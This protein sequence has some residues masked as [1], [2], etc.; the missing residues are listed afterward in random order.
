MGGKSFKIDPEHVMGSGKKLQGF[1]SKISHH[2]STLASTGQ[3]LTSLAGRDKSGIGSV[4][5]K[6][7]GRGVNIA[8][9]MFKE[10]GQYVERMGKH[11][12]GTGEVHAHNEHRVR[13]SFDKIRLD[14]KGAPKPHSVG[15]GPKGHRPGEGGG[16]GV[17]KP[18]NIGHNGGG[19]I[20][21]AM[22]KAG[23]KTRGFAK[24]AKYKLGFGCGDPVDP[25]TGELVHA[26]TDVELPAALPLVLERTHL[27][28]Y[29]AGGWFGRS[30]ASTVDE[31]LEVDVD[32]VCFATADGM[33]L[34]YPRQDSGIVE[35]PDEG[36]RWPLAADG[37]GGYT[38]TDPDLGLVRTFAVADPTSPSVLP[39]AT[40]SDRNGNRIDFLHDEQ[41]TLTEVCHCGGYR[42]GVHTADGRITT[43]WL[44]SADEEVP[45][46]RYGYDEAGNV[47]E[48][49]NSTG[50]PLRFAYDAEARI[51]GW[52]D[53]VGM[54]YRYTYDAEGRCVRTQGSGGFLDGTF[55]YDTNVTTHTDSLGSSTTF[56]MNG[57][58]QLVRRVDPLGNATTLEWDRYDR[59]LSETDALG[60]VV[61]LSYDEHGNTVEVIQPDGGRTLA[62]YNESRLPVA[63]TDSDGSVWRSEYDERANQIAVTDPM[64][65]TTRY[66]YDERGNLSAITDPMGNVRRVECDPAGLPIT[67]LD[68]LGA[69]VHHTRDA[70]G[71]VTSVTDP[72][73]R[74]TRFGWTVEG[75]P[76]W[77]T[78][79]DGTTERFT[80]DAEGNLT[81]HIDAMGRATRIG[82]TAFG[83]PA[84][85]TGP[86]GSRLELGYDTELRLTSFTNPQGQVWRYEYDAAG[87]LV[88]ETDFHGRVLRYTHDATGQLVERVNGLGE[89][90]AFRL[91][92]LGRVVEQRAGTAVA[93][94][95]Y[96]VAGR[97]KKAVNAD[98]T[99]VFE[100]DPLGR[101]LAETVNGRTV[102]S[103]FDLLGR[104]TSRRTP[105]GAHSVWE[106]DANNCPT[107]LRVGDR[108]LWFGYDAVGRET[109]RRLG[110]AVSLA[111]TWDAR[112]RLRTQAL[113]VS[114]TGRTGTRLTLRRAYQYRVDGSPTTII[115]QL[116]GPKEFDVDPVGRVLGVHGT[117]WAERYQYDAAGNLAPTGNVHYH[118]DAQGRVVLRQKKRLS[119]KPD[120]WRYEWDAQDRLVAV[121]TPDG[122]R[123][124]YR[125]DPLGRR[126]AKQHLGP[127]GSIADH[128]DFVWDGTVL[129]E[130][131]RTGPQA[132][133]RVTT[134]DFEPGGFRPLA[135][136]ERSWLR[137][138]P[139]KI[140]DERF[141]G[142][143]TDLVGTPT[144][145]IGPDGDIAWRGRATVWGKTVIDNSDRAY[146][147]LRFPGQ[148]YDPETELNYNYFRY[149]DPET[150]RYQS[151]D[152]LGL[153]AGL[154][155]YGYVPNPLTG[156]DPL[157]LT[158]ETECPVVKRHKRLVGRVMKNAGEGKV[159]KAPNYHG[160]VSPELEKKILANPDAV[161]LAKG[162][163][164]RV[165]FLKDGHVVVTEGFGK[166]SRIDERDASGN[167]TGRK[168]EVGGAA[169]AGQVVTSYGPTA[170]RG[171]SGVAI[172]GGAPTDPGFPV[173]HDQIVNGKIKRPDG[174]TLPPAVQ[175][176]P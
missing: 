45:L 92:V 6:V 77:R 159:R 47:A 161:Y 158:G 37:D 94:F 104:R 25:V 52:T 63:V 69:A 21:N 86:D 154:N 65:A 123:W 99:V 114:D 144:E 8:G 90:T 103:A 5:A 80:Y 2:G 39:L 130:Q 135:Q 175:I 160:K 117:G 66:A 162:Q 29:T 125:Y 13:S 163:N 20:R 139:Q 73:G 55:S 91:D 78:L 118:Y 157:G 132:D 143:V 41:G 148:Y 76:A 83:L 15:S 89:K 64:G 166:A 134:W 140:I 156:L 176:H 71:R 51:T 16:K 106:Y 138:A 128:V 169:R 170:P 24:S 102:S 120:T 79:P 107:T 151:G 96:D 38:I 53:R 30:W 113:T 98:A 149:Y 67:L 172:F 167:P 3:K 115:D 42:I 84:V 17:A 28:T 116:A 33:L 119:S 110:P 75:L 1:G 57:H 87:N 137:D 155:P 95:E 68:P 32:G 122:H 74:V 49:V 31:R 40:L 12:H 136:T 127:D 153:E 124:R 173:T 58:G 133:L 146:T 100:R 145:L 147:P 88:A 27:S 81:E 56:H 121:T 10:G 82:Y 101:V 50:L 126:I 97:L 11:L 35:L 174:S 7:M 70:F 9:K 93:T 150:G 142:I 152:P 131:S 14:G 43:L 26:Q 171:P 62:E 44:I 23:G 59:L 168:V 72:L 48:V 18:P 112:D 60:R 111:Q 108:D 4:I 129:A 165:L 61:R 164:N 36:P 141:Y 85:E 109:E 19:K 46:V 54:D 34:R 22:A 105:S